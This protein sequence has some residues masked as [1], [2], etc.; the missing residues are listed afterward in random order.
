MENK[1]HLQTRHTAW[2]NLNIFSPQEKRIVHNITGRGDYLLRYTFILQIN[3]WLIRA[4]MDDIAPAEA[5][6]QKAGPLVWTR[7]FSWCSHD[8][9]FDLLKPVSAMKPFCKLPTIRKKMFPSN[10]YMQDYWT[11]GPAS[12]ESNACS[13]LDTVTYP[14]ES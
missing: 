7:L 3:I 12:Q 13:K 2:R 14:G 9:S 8:A 1:V 10:V 5:S 4:L 6:S 11:T